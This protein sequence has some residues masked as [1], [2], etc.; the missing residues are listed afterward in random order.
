[1]NNLFEMLS[2]DELNRL[3]SFL[4]NR[5]PEDEDDENWAE[6]DEGIIG[7]SMLDGFFTAVVS[8]L[9]PVMPS[10]WLPVVWGDYEPVWES[11]N[12]AMEMFSLMMRHM[13]GIAHFLMEEPENFEPVFLHT[14][15]DGK[16][17]RIVD[18]WCEGY[19]M[20]MNLDAQYWDSV[21]VEINKLLIPIYI[22]GTLDFID[23]VERLS[24]E[25]INEFQD[26][27]APTVR[28]L[29]AFSLKH[30]KKSPQIRRDAPKTGRNDLCPCGSGLK[31][32]KC[33]GQS[34]ILH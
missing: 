7:I 28:A 9:H 15:R 5:V 26:A 17:Y 16:T 1:M 29:H 10:Q 20:G 32:K 3:D 24:E 13:N 19:L 2:Q 23:E 11:E 34:P 31:Y 12:D 21:K 4:L 33:C 25:K 30:R 6:K 22:F 18:D 8:N 14:I 27:I